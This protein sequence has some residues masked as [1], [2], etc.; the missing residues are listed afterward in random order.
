[1]IDKWF[2]DDLNEIYKKHSVVVFIDESG[3]AEFILDTIDDKY[4]IFNAHNEIEELYAKYQIEKN[5]SDD[6]KFLVYTQIPKNKL[7]FLREYCETNGAVEI[8]YLHNY[9][10]EKV[11][12]T[13]TLNLNLPNDE[14]IS[15]AKISIGKDQTYWMDLSHKGS[16]E[17]FEMSKE[18]LP[19]IHDPEEFT[20]KYDS[21]VLEI[22]YK[23][24]NDI[25]K[26]EYIEK[27]PKTLA[28]EVVNAIFDG[29]ANDNINDILYDVYC[30]WLDS[31]K[32][33]SSFKEY[34]DKY[35]L[36]RNIDI[37][38]VNPGH[39]FSIIDEKWLK[40][41]GENIHNKD[42]LPKFLT[43]FILRFQSPQVESLG[44]VYWKNISELIEFDEN[45]IA[46][47]TSFD[48][49]IDFYKTNFYKVD[50]A[51]RVLYTEFLNKKD[52]LEPFQE[53]YKNLV[54][55]FFEKW[56]G[57]FDQYKESQTGS[58]DQIINNNETKTAIIVGDGISFEIAINIASIT[59]KS[60][61]LSCE[62][63]MAGLP[64]ETENN[65]SHIFIKSGKIEA[66]QNKREKFLMES[67]N[68]KNIGYAKLDDITDE[69]PQYEYL[70]CS[71]KDFD[72]I[73]EKLQQNALKYFREA[74]N[75]IATKIELLLK[76][77]YKRVYLIS[78]H[79]YV[80]TGILNESD[81]IDVKFEGDI[82]KNERFVRSRDKQTYNKKLL[83]EIEQSYGEYNY[84]YFSK[85]L[86]PFKSIGAYGYSHGG[87]S[88]QEL[89]TPYFCWETK[90]LN[91]NQMPVIITNKQELLNITGELY[92]IKIKADRG[93]D[94]LF[95]SERKIYLVF[96]SKG[97]QLMK[98]DIMTI[99]P[100]EEIAKEY[101][102]DE[103]KKI[104]VLLLDAESKERLDKAVICQD[105]S[106]DLDGLL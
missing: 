87:I 63:I 56:F 67:N 102:F 105:K 77:G 44:I 98:S 43:K 61:N 100:E 69:V 51:I 12:T 24:V 22:F 53:Y 80:L 88:P 13:L 54:N 72:S 82:A 33:K 2:K 75:F 64:S 106:R 103:N 83:I 35:K 91:L 45:N 30:S 4:Q 42:Y 28:T 38:D 59:P 46:H 5:R 89:I 95:S 14:L 20:A 3:T 92:R 29:L 25:L 15:A 86:A 6:T 99:S 49:C 11:H 55:V 76:N 8:K 79:G 37:W 71:Y 36:P 32:Y 47:L 17:I 60:N 19:F 104:E 41:L 27:P 57:Y 26:Q 50:R 68:D 40:E 90:D 52:L 65:M 81:K 96:F 58:L 73:G 78:D 62:I 101:S 48:Q 85:T 21:Q 1:M 34:V 39:P 70:I 97:K 16:S 84:L 9:I 10:K 94:D 18:L 23:K 31:V 7:K 74:E 66:V 93:S